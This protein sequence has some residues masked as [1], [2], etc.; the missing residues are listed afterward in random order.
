MSE[1]NKA[2]SVVSLVLLVLSVA[3]LY[4]GVSYFN[5]ALD[6]SIDLAEET[7]NSTITTIQE[8]SFTPYESRV[9]S[10]L[11]SNAKIIEAFAERDRELLYQLTLSK[12]KALQKENK[13]FSVMQ[14]HL[15][16]STTFLRAHQPCFYGD[17]LAT[18]RPMIDRAHRNK[19][20]LTGY[21]IGS[22]GVFYRIIQP[23]FFQKKYIGA[24]ELGIDFQSVLAAIAL[25]TNAM[26]SFYCLHEDF[27]KVVHIKQNEKINLGSY[28]LLAQG[29]S[30][31]AKLPSDFMLAAEKQ[32]IVIDGKT[33]IFHCHPV[34]KNYLGEFIGGLVVVQ[35]ISTLVSE[36]K[37][38][39]LKASLFTSFLFILSICILYFTFGEVVGRLVEAEKKASNAKSNWELTFDAVPDMIYI[40]DAQ[41]R[42]VRTNKATITTLNKSFDELI[43]RR[44][45]EI[46]HGCEDESTCLHRNVDNK[47]E[48]QTQEYFDKRLKR[49]YMMT[50]APIWKS[51]GELFGSVHVIRDVTDQKKTE[52]ERVLVEEKLHKAKRMEAIGLMAGGVAHDLNNILSG[53]VSYPEL[54][55]LRLS[56]EEKMYKSILAIQDS[57]K[58]A[59]AVVS[60]LLTVAKG[61]ATVKEVASLNDLIESYLESTECNKLQ[62]SHPQL[63]IETN[64]SKNLWNIRCSPVHIQKVVMNLISNAA[65]S[66]ESTGNVVVSTVNQ[67]VES[68]KVVSSLLD[69][70][71]Y[72]VLTI[73]DSGTG[74]AP[75][76]LSRIFEPFYTKKVLGRSGTGL[77][78]AVVWNTVQDHNAHI[79]VVS[80]DNGTLFT[81]YFNPYREEIEQHTD[82]VSLTS[83]K[84]SG[85]VLVVDDE[86]QQR[87]IALQMLT[88]LGYSVKTVSSGEEAFEFCQKMRVDIIILDMLMAPGMNGLETYQKIVE[89]YPSQKAI[90]ASGFAENRDVV[91]SKA[92]GV[93]SFIKKPYSLNQLGR[94]I[95]K[96][97]SAG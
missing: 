47:Y 82:E 76:D 69:A 33:L 32:R 54:L 63:T 60:D 51:N 34:L 74:I 86:Q 37:F 14:F 70:G 80:D 77:G 44:C 2:I 84:G 89:L 88:L 68:S 73:Q 81:L 43:G 5:K 65:E 21:E 96:V 85:T 9:K 16:D 48:L 6:Q 56:K 3:L 71:E 22:H 13:Y 92:L 49:H 78:L 61:V 36:K 29:D 66:I 12:Y 24:L 79:N 95:K 35:D 19:T 30:V 64:L 62:S 27:E 55:L 17:K 10:L 45:C 8:L 72:V 4:Q 87:E 97:L 38:F 67:K 58:R 31:F 90:I 46:I 94:A 26:T 50:I 53:V 11:H 23:V 93:G 52:E 20:M 41:H 7:L 59:A 83:L 57:G 42:I 28:T 1:K 18:V 25:R 91:D 39:L 75:H 40:L 15:P